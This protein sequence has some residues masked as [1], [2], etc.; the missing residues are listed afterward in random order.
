V[1]R[2]VVIYTWEIPESEAAANLCQGSGRKH[3]YHVEKYR[4]VFY[5]DMDEVHKK[6]GLKKRYKISIRKNGLFGEKDFAGHMECPAT[7]M[8]N[9]TTH[10]LLYRECVEA[11]EPICI[12]EHDA[13]IVGE[14]PEAKADGVIQVSSHAD[15]QLLDVAEWERC[16]RA[17]KMRHHEPERGLRWTDQNGVVPH[18]LSGTNGTSGYIIAPGAAQKMIDVVEEGGVAFADRIRSEYIGEG[19]LWL[20][21][22]QSVLAHHERAKSLRLARAL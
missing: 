8:A 2:I 4:S 21:K 3:G 17:Q 15:R 6:Y 9:G 16:S 19:N 12:L 11:G 18:P 20:Q 5:Q 14:L 22:P 13:Q 1:V 10:Y 7:L